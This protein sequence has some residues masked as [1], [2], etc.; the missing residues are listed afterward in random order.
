MKVIKRIV[1][2]LAIICY[3]A[4][5]VYLI[6]SAPIIAGFHPIVVVDTTLEPAFKEGNLTYYKHQ[7][8]AD[9]GNRKF[10]AFQQDN[11]IVI[12]RV[13]KKNVVS[14]TFVT[15]GE[16][17]F[18]NDSTPVS[19]FDVKGVIKENI[20]IP[21]IGY[22]INYVNQHI[23][24]VIVVAAILVA[25]IVLCFVGGN[26]KL[27]KNIDRV[28]ADANLDIEESGETDMLSGGTA[29]G[30]TD[31]SEYAYDFDDTDQYNADYEYD[32]TEQDQE[33]TV[34]DSEDGQSGEVTEDADIQYEGPI[35]SE[36]NESD[37]Y[38]TE[39]DVYDNI[40]P[41]EI[42]PE[43]TESEPIDTESEN[44]DEY[45]EPQTETIEQSQEEEIE[46]AKEI[47]E[48]MVEKKESDPQVDVTPETSAL[49]DAMVELTRKFAEEKSI[50][51]SN[52]LAQAISSALADE[53]AA[54]VEKEVSKAVVNA[55][56]DAVADILSPKGMQSRLGDILDNIGKKNDN[57]SNK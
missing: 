34:Y 45:T 57:D 56:V 24:V 26:R 51:L 35:E 3:V 52:Q 15:Q 39:T 28:L 31:D 4:I 9:I 53:I 2:I 47:V 16:K 40:E 43:D 48:E 23:W 50:A 30:A 32:E 18:E 8:F 25:K 10:I 38:A 7:E 54:A 27:K 42:Q 36:D 13:V 12:R 17:S 44:Q 6:V 49:S 21:Y 5:G 33:Y 55:S 22:Y 14:Q 41:D 19:Y 46:M 1:S 37:F 20:K 29:A 11:G